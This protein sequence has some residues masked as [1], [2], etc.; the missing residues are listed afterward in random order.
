MIKYAVPNIPAPMIFLFYT[1]KFYLLLLIILFKIHFFLQVG[2]C[3]TL[4]RSNC[5]DT[6]F[7]NY[8]QTYSKQYFYHF[9]LNKLHYYLLFSNSIF[10]IS[11][12]N[13]FIPGL[14]FSSS[15]SFSFIA[16]K[17]L[18]FSFNLISL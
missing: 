1:T 13:F 8:S 6:L 5:S 4:T 11:N 3:Y 10:F 15:I 14:I 18:L 9:L 7:I 16:S 2:L 12:S 17:C